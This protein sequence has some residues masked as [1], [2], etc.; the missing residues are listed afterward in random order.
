MDEVAEHAEGQLAKPHPQIALR[1]DDDSAACEID[2][3][4]ARI[5]LPKKRD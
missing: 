1:H 4:D 3:T 2:D 5:P